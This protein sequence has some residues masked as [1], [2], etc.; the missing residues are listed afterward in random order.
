MGICGAIQLGLVQAYSPLFSSLSVARVGGAA[1][2]FYIRSY[3]I[4]QL[5]RG[6]PLESDR[7]RA[8]CLGRQFRIGCVPG[9]DFVLCRKGI[10]SVQLMPLFFILAASRGQL[11]NGDE[12]QQR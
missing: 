4:E 7:N 1:S 11:T 5:L 8:V 9:V 12:S 2:V 10:P 6:L 3:L